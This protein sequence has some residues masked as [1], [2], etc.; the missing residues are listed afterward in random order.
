MRQLAIALL[1]FSMAIITLGYFRVNFLGLGG[2]E[3]GEAGHLGGAILGFLLMRFP[4]LLGGR[5]D[6]VRITPP[7]VTKPR[8]LSKLRPRS[9]LEKQHDDEV[10]RILDKISSQGFQSLTQAEKDLL[11]EA[12]KKKQSPR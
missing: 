9:G 10:D 12:S 4:S 2:N 5:G 8:P 7:K 1:T 6:S 3:G 11:N